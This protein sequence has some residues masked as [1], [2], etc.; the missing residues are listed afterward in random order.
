MNEGDAKINQDI[1]VAQAI[2]REVVSQNP[3][4]SISI[5]N[6]GQIQV[7]SQESHENKETLEGRPSIERVPS[8]R[9]GQ[10]EYT[11]GDWQ[12]PDKVHAAMETVLD[13]LPEP[14]YSYLFRLLFTIAYERYKIG[15]EAA[16]WL[17]VPIST[18]YHFYK[19]FN[20]KCTGRDDL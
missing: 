12:V 7:S 20:L 4:A 17:G 6:I 11:G 9:L 5:V 1:R 2:V 10:V 18:V 8:P 14:R 16:E 13:S 3:E 19:R 15:K